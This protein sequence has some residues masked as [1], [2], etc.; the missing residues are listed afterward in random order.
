MEV[1]MQNTE[2]SEI[3]K[4]TLEKLEKHLPNSSPHYPNF[5]LFTIVAHMLVNESDKLLNANAE[6]D[7]DLDMEKLKMYIKRTKQALEKVLP[8]LKQFYY[9]EEKD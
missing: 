9:Q 5:V 1:T 7:S 2:Q 3:Q 8:D 4:E 6:E